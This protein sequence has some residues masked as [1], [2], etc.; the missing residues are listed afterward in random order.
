MLGVLVAWQG[1]AALLKYASE[2]LAA[3]AS[4]AD[5]VVRALRALARIRG[6]AGAG[7]SNG[8][9]DGRPARCGRVRGRGDGVH[10]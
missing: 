2:R 4:K 10:S 6:G 8:G 7:G 5:V 1:E 9:V 3:D